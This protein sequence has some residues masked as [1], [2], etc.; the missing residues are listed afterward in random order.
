M[1]V[2]IVGSRF[3]SEA[4]KEAVSD[5]DLEMLRSLSSDSSWL[6]SEDQKY[7]V[8]QIELM[9]AME[10]GIPVFTFVE[11][12]LLHDHY[13]YSMNRELDNIDDFKF[14]SISQPGVARYIFSFIDF[15][16]SRL[17]NNAITPFKRIDQVEEHLRRQWASLFQRLMSEARTTTG[18]SRRNEDLRES[19]EDL[20]V[21]VLSSIG[22]ASSRDVARGTV[23]YRYLL[24]ALMAIGVPGL[25]QHIMDGSPWGEILNEAGVRQ[26]HSEPESSRIGTLNRVII[27]M[28]DG[29]L[30]RGRMSSSRFR[31]FEDEW[32]SFLRLDASARTAIFDGVSESGDGLQPRQFVSFRGFVE[33]TTGEVIPQPRLGPQSDEME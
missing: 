4:I 19:I 3:G 1:V 26:V 32:N 24:D 29:R 33:P 2:L 11:E 30:L 16:N 10:L 5:I 12:G 7:S 13:N 21:A 6:N 22:T 31:R 17:V 28:E 20:K 27:E 14:A 23:R 25:G 8:T 15:L 9:K 18:E